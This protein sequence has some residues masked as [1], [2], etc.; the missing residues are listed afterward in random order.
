[1]QKKQVKA[2]QPHGAALQAYWNG[3]KTAEIGIH[4]DDESVTLM[5][6]VIYFRTEEDLP[7]I[8]KLALELCRGKILDVGAGAGTH[9]KILQK[10]DFNVTAID[11]CEPGVEIMKQNGV[12]NTF[13]KDFLEYITEEKYDTLIF[14]MNGIGIVGSPNGLVTYLEKAKTLLAAGGQII[15]DS[16]DLRN[17]ETELDFSQEYFGVFEYQLEFNNQIGEKYNWLYID[18]ELLI[19]ITEEN[20]FKCEI[21][22]EQEDGSYLARLVLN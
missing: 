21:I 6:I 1:M 4:M 19:K 12:I 7:E 13:C 2:W 14:L 9:S 16:S 17:G 15:L 20:G 22:Y 10:N 18:Q 5:P 3:N 8:E 11:I